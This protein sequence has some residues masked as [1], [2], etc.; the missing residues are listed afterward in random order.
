MCEAVLNSG[1]RPA[2]CLHRLLTVVLWTHCICRM[3]IKFC[4]LLELLA[5]LDNRIHGTYECLERQ[6]T[7]VPQRKLPVTVVLLI[8]GVKEN[9]KKYV[10]T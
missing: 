1:L 6:Q 5:R 2:C 4:S 10:L 9:F 3:G 8:E 7:A